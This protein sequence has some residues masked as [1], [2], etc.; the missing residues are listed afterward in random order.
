MDDSI[1]M[2]VLVARYSWSIGALEGG[3]VN[4]AY[5]RAGEVVSL[6]Q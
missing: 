3:K 5:T 4:P 6:S 1:G 2:R